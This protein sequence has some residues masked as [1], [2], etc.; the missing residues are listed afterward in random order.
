LNPTQRATTKSLI[1]ARRFGIG[2]VCGPLLGGVLTSKATWRWCFYINLPVGAVTAILLLLFFHPA[3]TGRG[4][5]GSFV[6]RILRLDIIGNFIL[7]VTVVM[8]LLVLQWGGIEYSWGSS[9]IIGLLVA[10]GVGFVGFGLWQRKK[11]DEALTPLWVVANRG[12]AAGI[13]EMF[14]LSGA[15]LVHTYYLP[16]WFQAVRSRTP[17]QSGV[18]LVPYV[19]TNFVFSMVAG[20]AVN[21]TGFFA[22]PAILGPIVATIGGGLLTTL[23]VDT[24]TATWAGYEVLTAAGMG[25]AMQQPIIATQAILEPTV[26]PIGNAIVLF[27]QSLSGAIF[28]SVANNV[29]R[30]QL[31]QSLNSSGIPNVNAILRAGATDVQRLVPQEYKAQ[32]LGAYNDALSKVFIMSVP[33]CGIAL[34]FALGL[35][36][37][38]LK[39]KQSEQ[40]TADER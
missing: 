22:A 12:V 37:I 3:K 18:D 29:L 2:A 4:R 23:R 30:N 28:V 27:A 5:E 31:A 7:V 17:V 25:M 9:R 40:E 13:G 21:M 24:S 19:A 35:P 26:V 20:I 38:N 6:Q 32:L 34:L 1:H 8:L 39:K 16:Y 11:G 14:F 15:L 33:F 36:W 10:A